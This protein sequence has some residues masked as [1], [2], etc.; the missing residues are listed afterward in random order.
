MT[1]YKKLADEARSKTHKAKAK[2]SLSKTIFKKEV[3]P[4]E[5]EK[6]KPIIFV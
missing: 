4:E 5:E 2:E 1:Y 3:E 6:K